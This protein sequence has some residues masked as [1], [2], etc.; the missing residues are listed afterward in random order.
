MLLVYPAALENRLVH[1]CVTACFM[2]PNRFLMLLERV[3][4]SGQILHLMVAIAVE[5]IIK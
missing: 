4:K 2:I 5:R 1:Y 3:S